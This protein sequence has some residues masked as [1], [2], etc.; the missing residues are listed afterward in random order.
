MRRAQLHL[1][2]LGT[3]AAVALFVLATAAANAAAHAPRPHPAQVIARVAA[4]Q[5]PLHRLP[6]GGRRWF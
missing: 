4:E 3:L 1:R 2:Q 5:A 6:P